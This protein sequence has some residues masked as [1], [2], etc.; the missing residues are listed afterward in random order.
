MTSKRNE[1]KRM[2]MRQEATQCKKRRESE[3]S[4]FSWENI[5]ITMVKEVL[6]VE[7]TLDVAK[8]IGAYKYDHWI[9]CVGCKELADPM[10]CK[11]ETFRP[12]YELEPYCEWCRPSIPRSDAKCEYT[13]TD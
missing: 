3:S 5:F 7:L 10:Y 13:F 9:I 12:G 1:R 6:N 4:N 11:W 8:V 2:G